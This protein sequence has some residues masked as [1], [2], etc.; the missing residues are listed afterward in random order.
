MLLSQKYPG[1]LAFFP[2][3]TRLSFCADSGIKGDFLQRTE[4]RIS[5]TYVCRGRKLNFQAGSISEQVWHLCKDTLNQ[6]AAHFRN[7]AGRAAQN[8]CPADFWYQQCGVKVRKDHLQRIG[9]VDQVLHED[10][11]L[12]KFHLQIQ[13][14][15]P[16]LL[17][18]LLKNKKRGF[19][20][21]F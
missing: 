12:I 17:Q 21:R 15:G 2:F 10:C 7:D 6:R 20:I 19:K 5:S 1:D 13:D 8:C 18:V 11:S 16:V 14:P 3:L 4:L 9:Q